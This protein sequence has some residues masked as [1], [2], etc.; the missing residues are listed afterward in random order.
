MNTFIFALL[1]ASATAQWGVPGYYGSPVVG[2][3][4]APWVGPSATQYHAQTE[5]GESSYGYA[6]PGAAATNVRD[7]FGNQ[8]G[9][10]AYINPEGKEVKVSY[11]AD[12]GGFRVL[13]ND[14]PVAPVAIPSAPL[15]GPA[16]VEDTADVV[17]AKIAHKKAHDEAKSRGKRQAVLLSGLNH[18]QFNA[19]LIYDSVDLNQDG[20]PDKAVVPVATPIYQTVAA[21]VVRTIASPMVYSSPIVTSYA[22]PLPYSSALRTV[23]S[24]VVAAPLVAK[25]TVNTLVLEKD[26]LAKTPADTKKVNEKIVSQ[27][28]LTPI[29]YPYA[30]STL[31]SPYVNTWGNPWIGGTPILGSPIVS[32]EKVEDEKD[33]VKVEVESARKK[34]QAIFYNPIAAE[35]PNYVED[36]LT[37]STDLNRDG[38]PDSHQ[39]PLVAPVVAPVTTYAYG[40]LPYTL[41]AGLRYW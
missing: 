31:A 23:V 39:V 14:L 20:Q 37:S 19:D 5:L 24:P 21:P 40:A 26:E 8:A 2:R 30:Y 36:F 25:T 15:V 7:A 9:S 33:S 38:M 34:R 29:A 13:S 28:V 3:W 22:S 27:E 1:V 6:Y 11:V 12:R 17:E 35:H 32:A 16:P 41:G 18:P 10:Y 4:G